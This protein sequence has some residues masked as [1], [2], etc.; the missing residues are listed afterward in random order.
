MFRK[1]I[2][3]IVAVIGVALSVVV[4]TRSNKSKPPAP[5]VSAAPQPPYESFVAGSGIIEANT[6]NIAIGT[7][8]PGIVSKLYV[9]IGSEVKA[10]DPLFTIDDRAQRALVAIKTAA[11]QVAQ[12]QLKH[13]RYELALGEG[14]TEKRVLSLEDRETRRHN[15]EAAETQL[16]LAT[17]ECE[18]AQTDLERLT[19]RAPIDGEVMQ[20]K[21][22]LGEF[23]PT[24]VLA[25]P[26]FL[27]GN[28]NPMSVRVNIDE[29]DAWRVRSGASAVGYLRG[30]KQIHAPLRFVRFEP[31]VVPKRSLTG[32]SAERVD[33]RVLQVIYNFERGNLPIFVGQQMD[34]YIDASSIATPELRLGAIEAE[35]ADVN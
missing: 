4:A 5:P 6:E 14:L 27:L 31:Y 17:A 32:D 12:A 18:A 21:V 10:G 35:R 19:V 24:G 2:L 34:I 33:T 13:A 22:R 15:A 23:A 16:A 11:I 30:N 3:P 20:L 9:Q 29:N 7:Q 25:Q 1:Y 28:L 8:L 26:L